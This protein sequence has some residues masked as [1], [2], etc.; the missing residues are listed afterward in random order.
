MPSMPAREQSDES[1]SLLIRA[2]TGDARAVTRLLENYRVRLR[3][4][5]RC[6]MD[7]RLVQ[8]FDPSDVVQEALLAASIK[9]PEYLRDRPVPFYPWL[10]RLAWERLL[11]L[12]RQHLGS[13]R[14]S[15]AR[16]EGPRGELSEESVDSLARSLVAR[17]AGPLSILI[18][19]ERQRRIREALV[20]LEESQREVLVLRYLEGLRLQEVADV[21]GTTLAAVK[22]RHLRAI[23]QLRDVIQSL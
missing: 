20:H 17:S 2:A 18:R 13:Q 14:R 19:E 5:V 7:A 6:R 1:E 23:R 21:L 16:E 15:V 11:D 22:M 3:R 9:L 10:R 4:M 8:R 12:Q